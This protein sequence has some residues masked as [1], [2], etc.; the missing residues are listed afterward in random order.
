MISVTL[1]LHLF[2]TQFCVTVLDNIRLY[3]DLSCIVSDCQDHEDM[4]QD[5][6]RE[7]LQGLR[8]LKD[9]LDSKHL[10]KHKM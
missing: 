8:E 4:D 9:L 1:I 7:F 6:D 2:G 10:D 3:F 5:L